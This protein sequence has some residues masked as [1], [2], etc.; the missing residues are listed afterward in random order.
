[1]HSH[2]A[3]AKEILPG[4]NLAAERMPGHWLLARLGK[5]VLRPG[6]IAM[7]RWLVDSLQIGDSDDVVELAPGLGVTAQIIAEFRPHSYT[8]V[9]RDQAA[10]AVVTD[11]I[12]SEH[13]RCV[14]G[15][16]ENSGLARGC[17]SIVIGEAML[18]MQPESQKARILNEANRLLK[19]NGRYAIHELCICP[20]DL[21]PEKRQALEEDLSHA[22]HVGV[23]P[24]SAAQW[25]KLFQS[26]GFEIIA[27]K[28]CPM[29][30]LSPMRILRDEGLWGGLR[31]LFRLL[32]DAAARRRVFQMRRAF[33]RHRNHLSA[34]ALIARKASA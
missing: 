15:R 8:G 30:L 33:R 7:T 11:R 12:G 22:I 16:A 25:R 19:P 26:H 17:A 23:R 14:V 6:G 20:D 9:E 2:P 1:M 10:A 34:I 31:F 3:T 29:K 27:E 5:R 18:S 21:S 32:A 24:L 28:Q 4:Q 13:A